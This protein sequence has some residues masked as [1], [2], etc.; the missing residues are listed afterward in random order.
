MPAV[1]VIIVA[2]NS[3]PDL[4]RAIDALAGQGFRD[5]TAVVWDNASS[6]GSTEALRLPPRV[7]LHR[8]PENLGFAEA[9][10]RAAELADSRWIA[11]LNPDAFPEPGWLQALVE[12]GERT[13]AAS[14]GSVQLTDA[15]P[16]VLDGLGDCYSIGGV[17]WRGGYLRPRAEYVVEDAEIFAPCAAAAL[18]RRDAFAAA[19]GFDPSYFAFFEDVD[20]GLRLRL[21]GER[22][23]V[24]SAAVVRHVGGGSADKVSGFAEYHGMRNLVRTFVKAMPL[25]LWPLALPAHAVSLV[26]MLWI[27]RKRGVLDHR[28]RGV[29]DG[30]RGVGPYL[31]ENLRTRGKRLDRLLPFL[32]ISPW[33]LRARRPIR[34]PLRP[35]PS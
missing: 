7:R 14:V 13:G 3:G 35:G 22:A 5:W 1:L 32:A 25:A 2:F 8:S 12:A 20:L 30:W 17:A 26:V 27:G 18:Y 28:W 33:S 16:T 29:I 31:I 4:Q 6:D 24:A 10:N 15:D 21:A 9:N 23:V 11:C 34:R 19:G